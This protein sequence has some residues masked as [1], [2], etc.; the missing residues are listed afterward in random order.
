MMRAIETFYKGCRFRSRL[1]ARWA[2]LLDTLGCGWSYEAQGF[3]LDGE[4]YLPDFWIPFA[5]HCRQS[6]PD[7]SPPESGFYVEIKPVEPTM[8]EKSLCRKLALHTGHVVY[9][10]GG[11]LGLGEFIAYKW[12]PKTA[13]T[14]VCMSRVEKDHPVKGCNILLHYLVAQAATQDRN[15][16]PAWGRLEPAVNTARAARFEYGEGRK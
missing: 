10:A 5:D 16:C 15:G 3:A 2:V 4:P 11:N 14:T 13:A 12:H 7:G 8:G 6:Y 1:E 9:L